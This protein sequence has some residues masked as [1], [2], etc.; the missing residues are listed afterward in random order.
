MAR[1]LDLLTRTAR[2]VRRAVLRRRRLVAAVLVAVAVATGVRAAAG[3]P[4]PTVP[5]PTAA[6]DLP[7]GTVLTE[8]DVT[9]VEFAEGT[10]PDDLAGDVTGRVLAA[11]VRRG[12]PVTDVRLVG[13][14]LARSH[15]EGTAL[16]VRLPDAEM[17]GLLR[18]GD[19][20]DLIATDPQAGTAIVVAD[21]VPV[22]ALPPADDAATGG[23]SGAV[24]VV[25]A[26]PEDLTGLSSAAVR[27]FLTFAWSR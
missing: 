15:P 2:R 3:P 21:D 4:P 18:V 11:P 6:R 17:A 14:A 27:L 12:E 19:V 16:P 5:V 9:T 24:V 7:A 26:A 20:I 8:A 13:P 23:Q 25:A 22:L 10:A 1:S